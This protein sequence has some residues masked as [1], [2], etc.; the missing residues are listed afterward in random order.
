MAKSAQKFAQLLTTAIYQIRLTESK[1]IRKS[2][3]LIQ[4]ELGYSLG[5]DGGSCIEYWRKGHIP[6]QLDDVEQ[7]AR[8]LVRRGGLNQLELSMFLKSAGHPHP[9]GLDPE[10]FPTM[11]SLSSPTTSPSR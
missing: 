6:A 9:V 11:S 7:L 3:S 5:R 8:E 2:I 4:D 10:L 1:T